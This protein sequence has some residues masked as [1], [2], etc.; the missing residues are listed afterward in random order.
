VTIPDDSVVPAGKP[1]TKTWQ[2][3]NA[4]TCTW[5]NSYSLVFVGGDLMQGAVVVPLRGEVM[6]GNS[7]EVSVD[8]IAPVKPGTYR[9]D[10]QLGNTKGEVFGLG[11]GLDGSFWVKIRV[12]Q[13]EPQVVFDFAAQAPSAMWKNN[14]G[15]VTFGSTDTP[16]NGMALVDAGAQ[17]EDG[18]TFDAASLLLAPDRSSE[19]GVIWGIF[20]AFEVQAGDRFYTILGCKYEMTGCNAQV[21]LA[22]RLPGSEVTT[23]LETWQEVYNGSIT[24]SSVD[25][26][27]LKGNTIELVLKVVSNGDAAE[28]QVYL[29]NPR[30]MR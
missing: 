3:K 17:Y 8:L 16:E 21:S 9:G 29:L 4:G 5:T 26:S 6:P 27:I 13:G 28:D 20:P 19:N 14:M 25:L 1:F 12:P 18:N 7:T 2:L 22:Y 11:A 24:T 30:V 15:A 10:W 23:T